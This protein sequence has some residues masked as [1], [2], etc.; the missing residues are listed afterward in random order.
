M[1]GAVGHKR[2]SKDYI[3]STSLP[4]TTIDEQQ[5]IVTK[6]DLISNDIN[7]LKA[8]YEQKVNFLNKLKQS[9]LQKAFTGELT[10]DK[11][12]LDRSLAEGGL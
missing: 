4:L 7:I 5:N 1:S 9:I 3:E 10:A 11:K 8:K 6:L 12:A 2:V